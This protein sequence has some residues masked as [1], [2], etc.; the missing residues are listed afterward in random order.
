MSGT[1]FPPELFNV[2][3]DYV[4]GYRSTPR[5]YLWTTLF[6]WSRNENDIGGWGFT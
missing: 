3:P 4:L 6:S 1:I 5:D 2:F